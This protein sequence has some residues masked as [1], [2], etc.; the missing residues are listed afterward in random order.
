MG[1]LL[2]ESCF[3]KG[4]LSLLV[5]CAYGSISVRSSCSYPSAQELGEGLGLTLVAPGAV[6]GEGH[7]V[8][9]GSLAGQRCWWGSSGLQ[10]LELSWILRKAWKLQR[11]IQRLRPFLE[12]CEFFYMTFFGIN[13]ATTPFLWV[14]LQADNSGRSICNMRKN[15]S[16]S[17]LPSKIISKDGWY[18]PLYSK[19]KR[20]WAED[21]RREME[22]CNISQIASPNTS[23][24]QRHSPRIVCYIKVF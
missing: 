19:L 17:V 22:N 8:S 14:I 15:G 23:S 6:A 16:Q 5:A 1:D 9:V 11:I 24:Y 21:F 18:T 10:N 12:W 3:G 20:M 7:L 2:W 4:L 13:N